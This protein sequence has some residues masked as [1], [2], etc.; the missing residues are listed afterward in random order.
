MT[1]RELMQSALEAMEAAI[2]SGDWRVDGACDPD[3]VLVRMRERLSQPEYEF[4]CPR[5]GHCCQ[6]SE[7]VGLTDE[8]VEYPYPPAKQPLYATAENTKSVRDGYEMGGYEIEPGYYSEEQ[9]DEFA[10]AI[11]AKLK[12]KNT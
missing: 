1:D 12:E 11:E 7:W 8:E 10:L 2:K 9:L 4:E 5:C 6:Q 3:M